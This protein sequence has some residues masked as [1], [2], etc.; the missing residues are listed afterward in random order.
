MH[1][2]VA[3]EVKSPLPRGKGSGQVSYLKEGAV[4]RISIPVNILPDLMPNRRAE[5]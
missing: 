2:H 5:K 4:E 3:P 1:S